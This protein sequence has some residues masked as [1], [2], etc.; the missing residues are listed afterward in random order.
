MGTST[1]STTTTYI[2]TVSSAKPADVSPEEALKKG[3]I[4][5]DTTPAVA[6]GMIVVFLLMLAGLPLLQLAVELRRG[7]TPQLFDLFTRTPVK[8]NL[9]AWED[10]LEKV[11]VAKSFFQPILQ[12]QLITLG[13]FGNTQVVFGRDGWLFHRVG[14]D[15]LT[16]PGILDEARLGQRRRQLIDTGERTPH[17]DPRPAVRQFHQQCA[18]AGVHLILMCVPDKSVIQPA[19]LSARLAFTQPIAPVHNA[20]FQRF[21]EELRGEGVDVFDPTPATIA[22]DDR[23]FLVQDTHWT[24]AWMESVARDLAAYVQRKVSLSP[25]PSRAMRVESQEV[26]RVGDLVDMMRLPRH[27]AAFPPQSVVVHRVLNAEN[28]LPWYPRLDAE[29][30]LLGNSFTNIFSAP[31]MGWGDAAGFGEHLSYALQRPVD[32]IARNDG[33]AHATRQILA[34]ERARGKDR[35]AGKKVVIW[36]FSS[37]ELTAGDWKLYDLMLGTA[38][39]RH[40]LVP[41]PGTEQTVTG[42]VEVAAAAPKPHISPY[43]DHI[44]AVHLT[45]LEDARGPIPGGQALVYM[46]SMHDHVWTKA[47]RY[48]PEQRVT[49]RLRPWSDVASKYEAINRR[50]LENSDLNLEEPC[51]GE[52]VER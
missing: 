49:V 36:Q 52:E 25:A 39:P 7:Q 31:P 4:R 32:R 2:R 18:A 43:K 47:A 26:T 19:Q 21:V 9:K 20:D 35:L 50:D 11:S 46:L 27:S 1:A 5:T 3:L 37:R 10:D 45:D 33:G 22:P 13:G 40:F 15:Y 23:R 34:A 14:V 8:T 24:P 42:T 16:G 38:P 51:W 30:L 17:P 41:K 29:V 28:D 48:H 44:I 6:W 12:E